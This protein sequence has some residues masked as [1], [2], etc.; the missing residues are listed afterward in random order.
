MTFMELV[1]RHRNGY[2]LKAD[3]PGIYETLRISRSGRVFVTVPN[4]ARK[5]NEPWDLER[6]LK[7][8]HIR[9]KNWE[10]TK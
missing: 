1:A 8:L 9:N 10:I 4:A 5:S 7:L 2:D 3:S 6:S